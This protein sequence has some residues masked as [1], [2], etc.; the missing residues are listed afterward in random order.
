MRYYYYIQNGI[1]TDHVSPLE[2]DWIENIFALVPNIVKTQPYSRS[3]EDL[4]DEIQEIYLTSVKKAIVD[5]VLRDHREITV[6]G[7]E[8]EAKPPIYPPKNPQCTAAFNNASKFCAA[9]L[10]P[11]N[12]IGHLQQ[13]LLKMW[14]NSFG[15][16]R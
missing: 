11:F 3:M 1:D 13:D 10:H 9:H 6:V 16:L 15:K 12:E 14:H 5:F 7:L 2:A 4:S 8:G